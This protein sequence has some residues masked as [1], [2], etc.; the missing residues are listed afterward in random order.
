MEAIKR[1]TRILADGVLS[2]SGL[3]FKKGQYVELIILS[4]DNENM[5]IEK[6]SSSNLSVL[7]NSKAIGIWEDRKDI[8]DSKEF[9]EIL[10]HNA[11]SRGITK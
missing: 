4:E 1:E 10:R 7:L 8:M 11:Q 9:A 6:D 3:P 2:V 5:G